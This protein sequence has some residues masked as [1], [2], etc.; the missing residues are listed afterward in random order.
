M[1]YT[2]QGHLYSVSYI[3]YSFVRPTGFH[4]CV[5]RT[6]NRFE[7]ANDGQI[8]NPKVS[9]EAVYSVILESIVT[10]MLTKS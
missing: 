3:K 7:M 4:L 2:F 10:L 9:A 5:T 6:T 8:L 1:N